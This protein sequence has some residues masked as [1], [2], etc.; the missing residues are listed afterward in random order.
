[1]NQMTEGAV[2]TRR[3]NVIV[4]SNRSPQSVLWNGSMEFEMDM[5]NDSMA[6]AVIRRLRELEV[7]V[8]LGDL[9]FFPDA[10]PGHRVI[11]FRGGN[12]FERI[13]GWAV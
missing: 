12:S 10:S 4:L 3:T 6:G 7:P 1:M 13:H 2:V 8:I 11:G 9:L 5:D